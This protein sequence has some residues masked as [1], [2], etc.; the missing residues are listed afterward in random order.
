MLVEKSKVYNYILKEGKKLLFKRN[1]ANELQDKVNEKYNTPRGVVSDYINDRIGEEQANE[2]ILFTLVDILDELNKT[3][4]L[5]EYYTKKEISFY[6]KEKYYV[7]E[8]KFPI[9]I[10]CMQVAFDQWIGVSDVAFLMKLRSAQMINYNT[11]AQ[12]TMTK[13]VK[14]ENEYYKITLN[15]VAVDSICKLLDANHFIPNAITLNLSEDSGAEYYYDE[16]TSELVITEL[17]HFDISDGYHRYIAFCREY[18]LDKNFNFNIELRIIAFEDL[19]VKRFIFQEDQKT[20]MTKVDSKSMNMDKESN[21]ICERLNNTEGLYL[22]G[23]I[24]RND[25]KIDFASLSEAINLVYFRMNKEP[26]SQQSLIKIQRQL[27]DGLNMIYEAKPSLFDNSI[28]PTEY[29]AWIDL[30]Y[31]GIQINEN[32]VDEVI[33]IIHK[34]MTNIT[35]QKAF[36]KAIYDEAEEVVTKLQ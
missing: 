15:E 22:E 5:E 20:I 23:Q 14:G 11:N 31:K 24:N 36:S 21:L 34:T 30:I 19:K 8:L 32:N 28:P 17:E 29:V 4:I 33:N 13:V 10:K 3:N 12:R 1:G 18:D 6:S 16:K 9:R 26:S 35:R 2:F 7:D 27:R 25:G